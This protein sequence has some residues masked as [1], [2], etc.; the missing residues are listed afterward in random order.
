MEISGKKN[1]ISEARDR[2]GAHLAPTQRPDGSFGLSLWDYYKTLTAFQV[3]GLTKE[4]NA[5][6]SWIRAHALTPQGDFGPRDEWD[7][8]RAYA[9]INSWIILG[10]HRLGR[11]DISQKA[12]NFLVRVLDPE[13]GGVYSHSTQ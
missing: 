9:Y 2:G 4:A 12:M 7:E 11:F 13:S 10:A 1:W 6:C 8:P 3:C 5:L